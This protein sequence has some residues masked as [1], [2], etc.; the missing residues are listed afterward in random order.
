MFVI[1]STSEVEYRAWIIILNQIPSIIAIRVYSTANA[2]NE[3][4]RLRNHRRWD[5]ESSI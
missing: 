4:K 2:C 1:L 3:N 5:K